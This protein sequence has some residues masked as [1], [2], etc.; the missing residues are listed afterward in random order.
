MFKTAI[1]VALVGPDGAGKTT[2]CKKL[3][4]ELPWPTVYIYMGINQDACNVMLPTTRLWLWFKKLVGKNHSMGGPPPV[5]R[6]AKPGGVW[7]TF[8]SLLR[9]CNLLAEEWYRQLV[10]LLAVCFGKTV[11]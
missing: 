8:K 7:R 11:V 2:I 9:M 4:S 5:V 1:T 3:C 6:T 10:C